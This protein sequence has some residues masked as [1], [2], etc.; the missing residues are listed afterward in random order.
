MQPFEYQRVSDPQAA[1]D[2]IAQASH[3][4]FLAGGTNLVDLMKQHVELPAQLID[5]DRIG[6]DKIEELPDGS[7]R[8]GAMARNSDTADHPLVRQRYPMLAQAIYSGASPQLRNRASLSQYPR[9]TSCHSSTPLTA[10][11]ACHPRGQYSPGARSQAGPAPDPS[12]APPHH[13]RLG[14]EDRS[15]PKLAP[16]KN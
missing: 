11:I 16:A 10:P 6:L 7:L 9:S 15:K 8:L 3:A 12:P 2:A 4:K 14:W 5:I 1:V 13:S